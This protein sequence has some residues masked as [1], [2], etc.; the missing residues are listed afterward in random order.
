MAAARHTD[1]ALVMLVLTLVLSVVFFFG[2]HQHA[3]ELS[4]QQWVALES[5]MLTFGGNITLYVQDARLPVV[6]A[7][8]AQ[9]TDENDTLVSRSAA[10]AH[11]LKTWRN[12]EA[13]N[14]SSSTQAQGAN[15]PS[16]RQD[17]YGYSLLHT[18]SSEQWAAVARE[19]D[20]VALVYG[21][22]VRIDE[23]LVRQMHALLRSS[24][25]RGFGIVMFPCGC[26]LSNAYFESVPIRMAGAAE[27][28][29]LPGFVLEHE[30]VFWA[31]DSISTQDG[32]DNDAA[33]CLYDPSMFNSFNY[34]AHADDITALRNEHVPVLKASLE[35]Q[36]KERDE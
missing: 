35:S 14:R 29:F 9:T 6:S 23:S 13:E 26:A 33:S 1:S 31:F 3:T 21:D 8:G 22:G 30:F 25:V 16:H 4:M 7:A 11:R 10:R 32:D 24:P 18:L 5:G 34:G 19:V 15:V 27:C 2:I 36:L 17:T 20:L 12:A 28:F